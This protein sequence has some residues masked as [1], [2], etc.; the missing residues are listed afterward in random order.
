MSSG[1]ASKFLSDWQ[2]RIK[3]FLASFKN[4]SKEFFSQWQQGTS[5]NL[6]GLDIG[7]D[8][9]KLLKINTVGNQYRVEN[10]AIA[11]LPPGAIVKDEIKE[12][13]TIGTILKT[14]FRQSG[15]NIKN[16]ALA[17]P[18]SSTIIKN[19]TVDK[20]LS[21][22]EIESRAW[23]EANR[24]FPDLVGDI[25]LDFAVAGPNP[26]DG[27]QIEIV[28]VACR[29]DQIKPYFEVL[30]QS[31]LVA[32]I[33]DVNCYALERALP[34]ALP[35]ASPLKTV[36]LLNLNFTLSSLIVVQ[37]GT[38]IHAH[39]QS[40]DGQR[41]ITQIHD[42]LQ[43]AGTTIPAEATPQPPQT[44]N[45]SPTGAEVLAD[46]EAQTLAKMEAQAV[47]EVEAASA[48]ASPPATT[49]EVVATPEVKNAP[50][51]PETQHMN[52]FK[53]TL[54]SHLRHTMHFFFSSRPG[55]TIQKIILSGDCAGLPKLANYIQQEIG[56]ET[57]IAD[58]FKNMTMGNINTN[59][60]QKNASALMV[61][62]G[63]ALSKIG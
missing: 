24:L 9:L 13:I 5:N 63:L 26:Q 25:Y 44:Q 19:I 41:L 34:L 1:R 32:K 45:A 57:E 47:A 39:D 61:C 29:K 43:K 8:S 60:L 46:V 54:S 59:D 62:C 31:G 22:E 12:P 20:R 21:P 48:A 23:I 7:A 30:K 6:V 35:Q 2:P 16:V 40:F 42:F 36:A 52:I 50:V 11:P 3:K 56:V 27:S 4:K 10:F 49:A 37:D 51:D 53:E 17:I 33:M 18:R 38:L 14:M 15:L 55:I 28:L 58:P